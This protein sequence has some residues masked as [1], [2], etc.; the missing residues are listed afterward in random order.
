MRMHL[1]M[2][3]RTGQVLSGGMEQEQ[4][5]EALRTNVSKTCFFFINL[6]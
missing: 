4:D 2:Q 5:K 3:A 6:Y 1:L